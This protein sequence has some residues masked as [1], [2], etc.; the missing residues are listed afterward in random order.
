MKISVLFFVSLLVLISFVFLNPL[1]FSEATEIPKWVRTLS[2]WY[3]EGRISEDEFNMAISFLLKNKIIEGESINSDIRVIY[4]IADKDKKWNI[5]SSLIDG[6]DKE[7]ITT[8]DFTGLDG[9]RPIHALDLKLSPDGKYFLYPFTK[10]NVGSLWLLDTET[11]EKKLIIKKSENQRLSEYHWSP[12]S[13]KITYSLWDIPPPCPQCGMPLYSINGPWYIYDIEKDTHEMIREK[14]RSLSLLGWWNNDHLIFMESE[15]PFEK[16][17]VYLF[18]IN[19]KISIPLTEMKSLPNV[20]I[21]LE[22][23]TRVFQSF[24]ARDTC[25]IL[26]INENTGDESIILQNNITCPSNYN[27]NFS[28]SSDSLKMMYGKGK[29]PSGGP[30]TTTDA[31]ENSVY[32]ISSVYSRDLQTGNETPI[33]LGKVN[34]PY[35]I[36]GGWNE[37]YDALAYIDWQVNNGTSVYTL[38]ISKSDG[39]SSIEIAKSHPDA[40]THHNEIPFYG[41]K[42]TD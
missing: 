9:Q 21:N 30:I 28:I 5:I 40:S 31:D 4:G 36:F 41:W 26:T 7:L 15:I 6:S 24:L 11:K 29:S 19:S 12:N 8:F 1:G 16:F 18:N 34:G 3:D 32:V 42:I 38:K 27:P 13:K 23:G 35:F 2:S 14:E 37:Q 25:E 33:F 17:P 20:I 39:S 22:E 10:D